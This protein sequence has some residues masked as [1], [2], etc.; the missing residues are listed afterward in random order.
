MRGRISVVIVLL[1]VLGTYQ[2]DSSQKTSSSSKT[3]GSFNGY[4]LVDKAGN[5]RKPADVR[6]LYQFLGT[7]TPTGSNGDTE[8]HITYAS[9]GAAQYYRQ[10][11]KFADGT[12]LVK[13]TFATDHAQMT[14]GDA[15]WATKT[16]V[17]F[18]M[19]KDTKN[20]FPNN[21]LWANGWGW[22][23]FKADAPDKQV[24]TS[25]KKDCLGCHIP[26]QST[27]WVYVQG[28][29]VLKSK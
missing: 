4:D 1:V 27:D 28:Y 13:E 29:P 20:R 5:I 22:A 14:T 7:Y 18:V 24:A 23:L 17:W 8:M 2:L 10:N 25:F 19:I 11:G 9:P 21:P 3:T 6:D 15:R 12:V 26:A 16:I